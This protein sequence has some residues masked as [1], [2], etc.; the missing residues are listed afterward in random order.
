MRPCFDWH[1][2][3]LEQMRLMADN[4]CLLAI[5]AAAWYCVRHQIEPQPWLFRSST[6]LLCSLLANKVPKS[7]GRS[8]SIVARYRQDLVDHVR[9]LIVDDV[10]EERS[11]SKPANAGNTRANAKR[12]KQMRAFHLAGTEREIAFEVASRRLKDTEACGEAETLKKS[13]QRV[14][15]ARRNPRTKAR[16]RLLDPSFLRFVGAHVDVID[17]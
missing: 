2:H 16:Y 4:G 13:Y 14:E 5:A 17:R 9:W 8:S 11:Y 1:E 10:I 15:R 12:G 7:R 6:G 3:N